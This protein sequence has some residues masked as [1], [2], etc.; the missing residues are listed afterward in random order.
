MSKPSVGDLGLGLLWLPGGFMVIFLIVF[1]LFTTTHDT[2]S[3]TLTSAQYHA[4]AE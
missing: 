2:Q 1:A 4:A 3:K